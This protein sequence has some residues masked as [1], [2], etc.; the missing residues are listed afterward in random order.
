MKKANLPIEWHSS[1]IGAINTYESFS[2]QPEKYAGTVFELYSVPIFPEGKPEILKAEEI[3]SN[4]Q[5]VQPNDI[6]V[7]KINPRI[8]RVWSVPEF[9]E[10]DQIASSEWIVVRQK[11]MNSQYLTWYFR[12][13][14]FRTRLCADVTGVGG[15]LTRAQPKQ[16]AKFPL[17]IPPLAE[18]KSS[19]KN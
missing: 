13:D 12:S 16:V 11:A 17:P 6:L 15:S 9:K 5:F 1:S 18:Q 2:M 4:K 19:P 7:C 10:L 8:N 3:G 14:E